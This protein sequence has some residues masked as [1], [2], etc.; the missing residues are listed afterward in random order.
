MI[1]VSKAVIQKNNKYLL[2]KRT[3]YSKS[4]PGLWDFTGGRHNSGE[5]PQE[6]VIREV[7]EETSFDIQVGPEINKMA[8]QDS[9]HDLLFHYF[10]P[11]SISGELKLSSEHSEFTWIKEEN[12]KNL[13]LHPAVKLFFN[14]K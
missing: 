6:A 8:H 1:E 9:E 4:Y 3:T 12:L 5:T 10:T 13:K 11:E 14:K 7:K 2:L